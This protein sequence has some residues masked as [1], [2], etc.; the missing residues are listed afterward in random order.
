MEDPENLPSQLPSDPQELQLKIEH[1]AKARC[2]ELIR[3]IEKF[4][5]ESRNWAKIW[6]VVYVFVGLVAV[7]SSSISAI[8]TF[9]PTSK[10]LLFT[11]AL[12]STASAYILTF[13]NPSGREEKRRQAV[14]RSSALLERV[15]SAQKF[16]GLAVGTDTLKEISN[17]SDQFASLIEDSL[18]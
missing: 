15:K 8:L 11:T 4:L 1:Q 10:I 9:F 13:L 16:I 7:I 12:S 5:S 3:D 18:Q 14:R 6:I 17:L 2:A